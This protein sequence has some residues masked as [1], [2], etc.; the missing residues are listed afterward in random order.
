[1]DWPLISN[2]NQE[3]KRSSRGW[4]MFGWF[5]KKPVADTPEKE[6]ELT[7]LMKKGEII[8]TALLTGEFDNSDVV[9]QQF[10]TWFAERHQ[11]VTQRNFFV[12][13]MKGLQCPPAI[14]G[15]QLMNC[16]MKVWKRDGAQFGETLVQVMEKS[17]VVDPPKSPEQAELQR[18]LAIQTTQWK[19]WLRSL[20]G[21]D[22]GNEN[23]PAF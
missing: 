11:R 1:L 18:R 14:V 17:L 20:D 2:P 15:E 22:E 23:P 16:I 5:K 10:A 13:Y 12:T 19:E 3:K 21:R 9:Q 6:S 4:S 8:I 7:K